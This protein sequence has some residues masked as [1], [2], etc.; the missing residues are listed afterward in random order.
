MSVGGARGA[1]VLDAGGAQPR[2]SGALRRG[3]E[4]VSEAARAVVGARVDA[5]ALALLLLW[6]IGE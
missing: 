4:R 2:C 1:L 6:Q 3:A 5:Q